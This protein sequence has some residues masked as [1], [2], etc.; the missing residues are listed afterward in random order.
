MKAPNP[1]KAL[2]L[3]LL[4]K[5][6]FE[7]PDFIFVPAEDFKNK[8]FADLEAFLDS[9]RESYKVI[10]RSAHPKEHFYKGGTFESLQ[11]YAD[12]GGIGYAR[13]RMI[14]SIAGPARISVLRQQKF[15]CAPKIDPDEMGVI[16]MPYI[17]GSSVM[18]KQIGNEWE[19]GYCRDRGHRV[20][21]EPY[22]TKTPHDA[23]LLQISIDIQTYLGCRCEI[24]YVIAT[25]GTIHPVQ[26]KDISN[27]DVLEQ[28]ES[29]RSVKLDGL[30][31]IR[32]RRNYRERPI[33]VMDNQLFLISIISKCEDFLNGNAGSTRFEDIIELINAYEAELQ[34]FALR[35]ERFGV[36]G[37]SIHDPED[38]FQIANHYLDQTPELQE[39]LS[40]ALNR[41]IYEIDIFLSEAD[42]LIAK[43][44]F[45]VN[46]CSHDAY[47]ISTVRN[48]IW[49][50][51]WYRD[52][53]KQILKEVK[54]IGFRTG[55]FIGIDVDSED[56]P[57]AFRL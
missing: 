30:R 12:V 54:R 39:K 49:S 7:V 32:K 24:E 43:D 23:K 25:D 34:D 37:L 4:K 14:K 22:I 11:T 50:L 36:L 28:K 48:P 21:S 5:G 35:N 27:I 13:K 20:Q 45:R 52:R 19:F 17:D 3:D 31:R 1:D 44:M 57:T 40:K 15:N 18:A 8:R 16:V 55:D 42:T 47:G 6:G 56:K 10:A 46:L 9:H 51:Y 33:Y 26:A 29:K 41:N 2:H 53:H 38:L